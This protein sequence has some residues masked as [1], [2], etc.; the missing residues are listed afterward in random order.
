M[1]HEYWFL[2]GFLVFFVLMFV[3]IWFL[4]QRP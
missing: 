4:R 2:G 1:I 3:L